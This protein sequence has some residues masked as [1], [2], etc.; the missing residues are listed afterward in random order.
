VGQKHG[1]RH[2][3]RDE[4]G[5]DEDDDDDDDDD[6]EEEHGEDGKEEE[7]GAEEEKGEPQEEEGRGQG[8]LDQPEAM[9]VDRENHLTGRAEQAA[10]VSQEGVIKGHRLF[11]SS[12]LNHPDNVA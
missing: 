9:L 2:A 1:K 12:Y 7:K 5:D 11:G 10:K 6:E 4:E 8:P 3:D